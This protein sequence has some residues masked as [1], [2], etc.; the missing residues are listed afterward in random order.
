MRTLATAIAVPLAVAGAITIIASKAVED[1][2]TENRYANL[3]IT[4][5]VAEAHDG[6]DR[7]TSR[8]VDT[9]IYSV[10]YRRAQFEKDN[11]LAD[12]RRLMR[13]AGYKVRFDPA[14]LTE[15][16]KRSQ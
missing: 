4:N 15:K 11:G 3:P 7:I 10:E 8:F 1:Y 16:A 2:Q 9:D 13:T 5:V 14:Y 12:S 6:V